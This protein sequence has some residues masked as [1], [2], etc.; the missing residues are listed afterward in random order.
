MKVV[1]DSAIQS[2]WIFVS[3]CLEPLSFKFREKD[4]QLGKDLVSFLLILRPRQQSQHAQQ[5]QDRRHPVTFHDP[6]Y[7]LIGVCRYCEISTKTA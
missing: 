4:L 3:G 7:Q 5:N 2:R 1:R 6:S